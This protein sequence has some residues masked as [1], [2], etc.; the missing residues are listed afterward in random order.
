MGEGGVDHAAGPCWTPEAVLPF[1]EACPHVLVCC[2]ELDGGETFKVLDIFSFQELR[3]GL[4]LLLAGERQE[5]KNCGSLVSSSL[6]SVSSL[7][8][9]C[10]PHLLLTAWPLPPVGC[11]FLHLSLFCI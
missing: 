5:D 3:V 11:R 1:E 7:L 10:F 6:S 8:S 9:S 4:F 2:W